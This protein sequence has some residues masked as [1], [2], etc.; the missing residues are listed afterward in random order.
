[1]TPHP[2]DCWNCGRHIAPDAGCWILD[3][4]DSAVLLCHRCGSR[5]HARGVLIRQRTAAGAARL[6]STTTTGADHA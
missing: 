5:C 2:L 4:G 3:G 1:M 6:L